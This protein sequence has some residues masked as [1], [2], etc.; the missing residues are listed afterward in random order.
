MQNYNSNIKIPKENPFEFDL[1]KREIVADNLTSIIDA[2]EDSIVISI[3]SSWG[4]GKTTFLKMWKAKL[5]QSEQYKTIY[6]NAWENDDSDDPLLSIMTVLEAEIL[7]QDGNTSKIK[8]ILKFGKPILK[9]GIPL[10]LKLITHGILDI[11][12]VDLGDFKDSSLVEFSEKIGSIEFSSHKKQCEL[13][14][15]LKESLSQYQKSENRKIVFFVDELD[16]CRPIFAIETLERIKHLFNI[17]NF[18]FIFAMDRE[19]LAHSVSTLYGINMDSDNYLK[20]FI[21]FD[22]S[23]DTYSNKDY[24][25]VKLSSFRSSIKLVETD[26]FWEILQGYVERYQLSFRQINKLFNYLSVIMPLS[27]FNV[28]SDSRYILGFKYAFGV[29][30]S[31]LIIMRIVKPELYKKLKSKEYKLNDFQEFFTPIPVNNYSGLTN[32]WYTNIIKHMLKILLIKPED[33]SL[34]RAKE[35]GSYQLG[36]SHDGVNIFSLFNSN[37]GEFDIMN[38]IDFVNTISTV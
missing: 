34:V 24:F 9:Q 15:K 18:Y 3:D 1:L 26:F 30:Y 35:Y 25:N 37:T 32:D 7:K 10:A 27:K 2:Y 36:D 12:G 31:T 14:T 33:H 38:H 16:R 21:D 17:E 11:K 28:K 13:K 29:I 23:F 19:Q 22:F 4:T 20:R 5:E 8:N 6:F